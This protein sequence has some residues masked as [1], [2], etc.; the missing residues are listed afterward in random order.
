[1]HAQKGSDL[2][3]L[4]AKDDCCFI[5]KKPGLVIACDI[6]SCSKVYHRECLA[7]GQVR[8]I[9]RKQGRLISVVHDFLILLLLLLFQA[10]Q[11]SISD[12]SVRVSAMQ[13]IATM[14][15]QPRGSTSE[16]FRAAVERA[17]QQV[18]VQLIGHLE[19]CM[20][21]IYLQIVARMAD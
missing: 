3:S 7:A 2:N 12:A 1:M 21:E 5:C 9:T 16:A 18:R 4:E 6:P 13:K 19:P 8:A 17:Q 14:Y 15:H 10:P 11:L 20:T